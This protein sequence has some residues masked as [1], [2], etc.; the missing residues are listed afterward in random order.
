MRKLLLC[1]VADKIYGHLDQQ[2]LLPEEQ[3]GCSKISRGTNHLLYIDR[4]VIKVNSRKKI[5]NGMDRL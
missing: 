5:S 4:A 2:K 1:V 3:K